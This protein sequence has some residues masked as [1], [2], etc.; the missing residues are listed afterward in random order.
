MLHKV[1]MDLRLEAIARMYWCQYRRRLIW[2][3]VEQV[4][5]VLLHRRAGSR[6]G[7]SFRESGF[8]RVSRPLLEKLLPVEV[9]LIDVAVPVS[10]RNEVPW[11][12]FGDHSR[13]KSTGGR[14]TT[15]L[16]SC[17][18]QQDPQLNIESVL[19]THAGAEGR[20]TAK[21]VQQV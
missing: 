16:R 18:T 12:P 21:R 13:T 4:A 10:E 8:C 7:T 6:S 1:V 9:R 2:Q 17:I 5:R 11:E 15:F 3:R 19:C 14:S 20:L